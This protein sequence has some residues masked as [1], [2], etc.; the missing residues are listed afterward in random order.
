MSAPTA[1]KGPRGG[2]VAVY[3]YRDENGI[4]LL[5][6]K[7]FENKS[8]EFGRDWD[9]Q[10]IPGA[11]GTE[12]PLYRADELARTD[13]ERQL[14][15]C[16]G[17]KDAD[18]LRSL[19]LLA[20]TAPCGALG[21]GQPWKPAYSRLVRRFDHVVICEDNDAS[22]RAHV[23]ECGRALRSL[24]TTDVRA[25][26]FRDLPE[27]A[28]VSDWL[29]Q[30]H[31]AEQLI[32]LAD[33]ASQ[34]TPT[35][36]P[37]PIPLS[38]VRG[39]PDFPVERLPDWL[40]EFVVSVARETQTA[41]CVP[42]MV[43]LAAVAAT[44]QRKVA[45]HIREGWTESLAI[46][47]VTALPSANLKTP[48]F[49][50]ACAP[51]ELAERVMATQL[52][53][54]IVQ[55]EN[56]RQ[57]IQ[58]RL[59]ATR[60]CAA[61]AKDE[62]ERIPLEDETKK[63]A[64]E[65]ADHRVP[66][67]PRLVANDVT[68]ESLGTLLMQN[69]GRIFVASDEGG[70]FRNMAGRYQNG[71]PF[72]EAFKHGH[73][74]GTIRVDRQH[75][76]PVHVPLA[77]I[78]LALMVQPAVLRSLKSTPEFRGEGLLARFLYC[79]PESTVGRRDFTAEG[80]PIHVAERYREK[81]RALLAIAFASD[82]HG[83]CVPHVQ[84]LSFP[85]RELLLAFRVGLEPRL[86]PGGD[87]AH[88]GDWAGKLAGAAAR[89]AGI[90]HL[91]KFA[92]SAEPWLIPIQVES[93]DAAITI[94]RDFLLPH[95]LGAFSMIGGGPETELA[96]EILAWVRRHKLQLFTK[97]ELHRH[98]RRRVDNPGEWNAPLALLVENGWI[99]ELAVEAGRK[100]RPSKEYEVNPVALA[101]IGVS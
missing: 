42:A 70:P 4:L 54:A 5:K 19:G 63:L 90:L 18:R 67:V 40:R 12:I 47:S 34:W 24:G 69:D 20:T 14:W 61:K 25:I 68:E 35:E 44:V 75:R 59:A 10:W 9:G 76:E 88:I 45:V 7:R 48:V 99:R 41:L 100:G 32:E 65:L 96:E 49:K 73:N 52:K 82:E 15:I 21:N 86:G 91:A 97:R 101:V 81:V 39:L 17:E 58:A 77:S 62:T 92:G 29:D 84:E 94:A 56:K 23:P 66:G 85:A 1:H 33:Q 50:M 6:K 27:H 78:T 57:N 74:A 64:G 28:D 16:E 11:N 36:W 55:A 87:L 83:A 71:S 2:C 60:K 46:Y 72:F 51:L 26:A 43:A 3:E 30:G 13:T 89:I 93:M 98:M 79:I 80:V 37:E 38:D 53:D 22:G 8:F 95:A 31:T